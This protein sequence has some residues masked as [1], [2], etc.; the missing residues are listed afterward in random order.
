[1]AAFTKV[2]DLG[3]RGLRRLLLSFFFQLL[4]GL[5][6]RAPFSMPGHD[7][8]HPGIRVFPGIPAQGALLAQLS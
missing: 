6:G 8:P 1:M 7:F 2:A 4:V 3:D 5:P